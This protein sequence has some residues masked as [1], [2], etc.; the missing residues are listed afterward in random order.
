[1]IRSDPGGSA[2]D[3]PWLLRIKSRAGRFPL[4]RP[5]EYRRLNPDI[6][7][8]DE[9]DHYAERGILQGRRIAGEA[10]VA[11][12]LG[13]V[14]PPAA[15][16]GRLASLQPAAQTLAQAGRTRFVLLL[17]P[18]ASAASLQLA[19]EIADVLG[20][21]CVHP[22]IKRSLDPPPEAGSVPILVSP[23][24]FHAPDRG[25]HGIDPELLASSFVADCAGVTGADFQ[26]RLGLLL[27]A[28]GVICSDAGLFAL[29]AA[30]GIPTILWLPNEPQPEPDGPL[31]HPLFAG[32]SRR[33]RRTLPRR[34]AW[35]ERPID[36]VFW[37]EESEARGAFLGRNADWLATLEC[38]VL[39]R[40][41]LWTLPDEPLM[42]PVA[43]AYLGRRAKIVLNLHRGETGGLD[44]DLAIG[45]GMAL[46]A[47]VVSLPG[48]PHPL[49]QAG[50]HF[51]EEA[52][53]RIPKLV[54][55]LLQTPDGRITAERVRQAA[56]VRLAQHAS[57]RLAGLALLDLTLSS[58]RQA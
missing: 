37:G 21:L 57:P 32:L 22:E 58:P 44:A 26:G 54:R 10:Q 45:N 34:D 24:E 14:R 4:F 38:A 41:V 28:R 16:D 1:M 3:S 11:A 19:K 8:W 47:L 30:T 50:V 43:A 49:F 9:L 55:W 29:M 40:R 20:R 56:A 48:L 12:C 39:Y 46:G 23:S 7:P 31:D 27:M 42:D 6:G 13:S 25:L 36:L 5:A 18:V 2:L 33:A 35:A 15:P 17:S 52:P 51:L 53:G